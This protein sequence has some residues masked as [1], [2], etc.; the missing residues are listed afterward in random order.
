MSESARTLDRG[1]GVLLGALLSAAVMLVPTAAH[2]FCRSTTC[3]SDKNAKCPTDDDGCP[4][5]GAKLFWPTSCV[6]YAMNARGTASL[7]PTDTRVAIKKAFEAW[8]YV[9]C[10][11]GGS[12]SITFEERDPVPCDKSQFHDKVKNPGPNVNV[13]L[14]QDDGWNYRG[15]DGTLA[16]TS[17]TYNDQTGE[18]YDA[19]IEVNAAFNTLTITDDPRQ[20]EYDVQAILTHEVG[21]FIGLAHSP[22]R[23][24]VMYASYAPGDLHG[25]MLQPDDVDAVCAAYPPS[26][27]R[28]CNTEPIGGFGG[29]CDD[30]KSDGS[31]SVANLG[32][33]HGREA[34]G[35]VTTGTFF[36][37]GL[38]AFTAVRRN[39]RSSVGDHET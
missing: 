22:D 34:S 25:R 31:C 10:D 6:S 28:A 37:L 19:D 3:R 2:A 32:G 29:S 33:E 13:V 38:G 30:A 8:S 15:E 9:A 26:S 4:S 36:L 1:R 39:R 14:F 27:P 17:V 23:T 21:H 11:G 18:I 20:A 5:T 35:Y 16:K 24:A 12:A 7:D